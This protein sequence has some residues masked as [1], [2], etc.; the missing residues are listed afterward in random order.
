M[1][2]LV[3]LYEIVEGHWTHTLTD[4]VWIGDNAEREALA[5]ARK[6]GHVKFELSISLKRKLGYE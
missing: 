5:D 3:T 2:K 6:F 4:L 1:A